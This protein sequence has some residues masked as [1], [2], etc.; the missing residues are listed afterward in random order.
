MRSAHE[1]RDVLDFTYLGHS[2][3]KY[4]GTKLL[5]NL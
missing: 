3:D 5:I 1:K 4:K 2:S